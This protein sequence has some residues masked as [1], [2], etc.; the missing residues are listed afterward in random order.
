MIPRRRP[1]MEEHPERTRQWVEAEERGM[2]IVLAEYAHRTGAHW[3]YDGAE[4]PRR[5]PCVCCG[6]EIRS[7]RLDLIVEHLEVCPDF[8]PSHAREAA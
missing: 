1:I 5:G 3:A 7:D 8:E 6:A 4:V 2:A